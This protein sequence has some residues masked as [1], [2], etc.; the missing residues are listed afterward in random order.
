MNDA[1]VAV[2]AVLDWWYPCIAWACLLGAV[3][4]GC[5]PRAA[6]GSRWARSAIL[7][8]AA[9]VWLPV[10]GM[11]LGRWLHGID[12]GLSIP[13]VAVLLDRIV[14]TWRGRPLLDRRGRI[15]ACWFGLA[16]GLALYPAA[17][18]L[19]GFDP[20]P[21]GWA[22][23]AVML[24]AAALA[25]VLIWRGNGFGIVLLVAGLL[26][27]F[28]VLESE[29]AWDYLVDPVYVFLAPLGLVRA[30]MTKPDPP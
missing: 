3:A 16:A 8:A 22:S 19:G 21:L 25:A 15:A 5:L 2:E 29:N 13:L 28:D 14:E 24:A 17:L 9:A 7:A 10:G 26:W 1:W 6:A 11:P 23:P 18:G 27:Q 20:Y 4:A 12:G 30:W